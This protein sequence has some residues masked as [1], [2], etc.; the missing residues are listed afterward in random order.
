MTVS[1]CACVCRIRT[2]EGWG[3][4]DTTA[5]FKLKCKDVF[6]LSDAFDP[7]AVTAP[8]EVITQ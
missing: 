3:D 4:A 7:V 6:P 8:A 5:A 1:V 2:I